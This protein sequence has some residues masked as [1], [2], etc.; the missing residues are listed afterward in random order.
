MVVVLMA[1]V[2]LSCLRYAGRYSHRHRRRNR[3]QRQRESRYQKCSA[4]AHLPSWPFRTR[5]NDSDF[6]PSPE[7]ST[8]G[9]QCRSLSRPPRLAVSESK[10]PSAT[11]A[12][13]RHC[14]SATESLLICAR[15]W[16]SE[17]HLERPRA[18]LEYPR[19]PHIFYTLP[20]PPPGFRL[21]ERRSR[22]GTFISRQSTSLRPDVSS[23]ARSS[24]DSLINPCPAGQ[25]DTCAKQA[26]RLP[27]FTR[28]T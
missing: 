10:A 11:R 16:G 22:H 4:H 20:L 17:V 15:S 14:A 28:I 21:G 26:I 23:M 12:A 7:A 6:G 24:S 3:Y 9:K 27:P 5:L 1:A 18:N 13:N 2:G 8:H 19:R 25:S